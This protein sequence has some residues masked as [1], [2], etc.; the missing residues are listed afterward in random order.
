MT[1]SA[2]PETGEIAA[3]H[4]A[5]APP[6]AQSTSVRGLAAAIACIAVFAMATTLS[7]PLLAILMERG[8]FSSTAIG[9]N[10][11]MAAIATLAAAPIAPIVMAR[12]GLIPFLTLCLLA[13]IVTMIGFKL[14]FDYAWWTFLRLVLGAAT[15]GM[16]FATE[17]WVV[18]TAPDGTRGR[19]VA[20]YAATLSVGYALGPAILLGVGV[21]GLAGWAPFLVAG[22]L[23]SL[24]LIPIAIAWRDAPPVERHGAGGALKYFWTDP[25]LLWAV[26]LFG[27]LEFGA[28]A[29]TPVWGVK[30]GMTEDAG[31]A[32]T[33]WLAAG[34][35]L[36]QPL[37]GWAADKFPERPLLMACAATSLA[38]AAVLPAIT[39]SYIAVTAL[40][41]LW[42]GM[43]AGLYTISLTAMG[44]RYRG[45]ALAAANAAIVTAYG[46][47]ALVGPPSV[48]VAM[49]WVGSVGLAL[50]AGAC[51][52]AY[53]LLVWVRSMGKSRPNA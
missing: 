20:A 3:D 15:A 10:T 28:M 29:L 43:A 6:V 23:A 31:I 8:G 45:G 11:A 4:A 1:R 30:L 42:G 49:D 19:I 12:I 51:S 39:E 5:D 35:L 41:F 52:L 48:G 53:L 46:I 26:V 40:F 18:A 17:Y 27:V 16:F 36:F 21:D 13:T 22:T 33:V 44:G 50:T 7:Y 34:A 32:L 47:G 37:L 14:W 38:V 2:E 24:A 9:I 25:S